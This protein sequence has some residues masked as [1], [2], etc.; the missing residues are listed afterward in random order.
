[1]KENHLGAVGSG[2]FIL[3]KTDIENEYLF[4]RTDMQELERI[5][6][7]P[8]EMYY[9]LSKKEIFDKPILEDFEIII[10]PD[11]TKSLLTVHQAKIE[12]NDDVKIYKPKKLGNLK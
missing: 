2:K 3:M 8:I 9:K 5:G 1:M 10:L 11:K 7:K 6:N 12:M 4:F